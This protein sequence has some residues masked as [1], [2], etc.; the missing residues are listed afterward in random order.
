[1]VVAPEPNFS[2]FHG[3]TGIPKWVNMRFFIRQLSNN[4]NGIVFFLVTFLFFFLFFEEILGRF[5]YFQ[6]V[7]G[8]FLVKSHV[9]FVYL[10]P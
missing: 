4:P 2:S 5:G 8:Y 9:F 7:K 1:M 3:G 6:V 10:T